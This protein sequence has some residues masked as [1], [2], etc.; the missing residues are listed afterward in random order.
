MVFLFML[1]R[2]SYALFVLAG[3]GGLARHVARGFGLVE[4]QQDRPEQGLKDGMLE[5]CVCCDLNVPADLAVLLSAL[6]KD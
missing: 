3:F 5:L 4:E 1:P 6:L 2:P